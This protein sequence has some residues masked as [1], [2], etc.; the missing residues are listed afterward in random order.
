MTTGFGVDVTG[1]ID[2]VTNTAIETNG[3]AN[4]AQ[5]GFVAPTSRN[6][7]GQVTGTNNVKDAYSS[8][9][10]RLAVGRC[11]PT[12]DWNFNG[13]AQATGDCSVGAFASA[14]V[15]TWDK[16]KFAASIKWRIAF[17]DSRKRSRPASNA[18][19]PSPNFQRLSKRSYQP[20]K[21]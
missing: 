19:A 3:P 7:S 12:F 16:E 9:D 14:T 18:T 2:P 6:D 5:A 1:P 20:A 13:A 21:A 10:Y 17:W 4:D 8:D 15:L 11:T